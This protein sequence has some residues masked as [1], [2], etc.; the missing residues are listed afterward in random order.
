M[1]GQTGER[2]RLWDTCFTQSFTYIHGG[3]VRTSV[4]S[5]YRQW[6]GH[7]LAWW[8]QQFGTAGCTGCGRNWWQHPRPSRM[9]PT[10]GV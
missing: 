2:K 7:K 8:Q 9:S 3:S 4:K 1:D 5:R 6:L 10:T